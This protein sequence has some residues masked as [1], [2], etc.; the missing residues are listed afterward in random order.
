MKRTT[1]GS[2]SETSNR[3]VQ[4][5]N[6]DSMHVQTH[7][8]VDRFM[9][10]IGPDAVQLSAEI[11]AHRCSNCGLEFSGDEAERLRHQAVCDHLGLLRPTRIAE[12]RSRYDLTRAKFAAVSRIGMA[13]LARWESGETLQNA[14]MDVYMR[15]LSRREVYRLVAS[16]EIF[17]ESREVV[18]TMRAARS[19]RFR[20][21]SKV[22]PEACTRLAERG[23]SF[24]LDCAATA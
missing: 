23:Q 20:A 5:P 21:L 1:I 7:T 8:K 9:Y 16:G 11:P 17:E 13:T 19:D 22:E 24:R 15:L 10:G 14:A 6:C 4:C 18:T 2:T 3:A 12:V